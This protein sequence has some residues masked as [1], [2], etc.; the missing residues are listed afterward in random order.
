M[1]LLSF[2]TYMDAH[3]VLEEWDVSPFDGGFDG[4]RELQ[5][6]RFSGAVEAG[7]T[8]LFIRDGEPLAVLEDLQAESRPGDV[9]AFEDASG[10]TH[11]A[12]HPAAASLAAMLALGGEVRGQYFTDDT[13]LSKVHETLSEGGFTGYVELSENVLSGDYYVVYEGGDEDYL[14]V[15]GSSDRLVTSEEAKTKA[16]DEVGIYEVVAVHYPD[17]EIPDPA[18]EGEATPSQGATAGAAAGTESTADGDEAD[19]SDLTGE[20]ESTA[21]NERGEG[22]MVDP[23]SRP[24]ADPDPE[25]E[26]VP[27]PDPEP[28]SE[29]TDEPAPDP[30]PEP[31]SEPVPR[32]AAE[33]EADRREPRE[34]EPTADAAGT[35]RDEPSDDAVLDGVTARSVPSLDPERTG[36]ADSDRTS[37]VRNPNPGRGSDPEPGSEPEPEP[38]G[39]REAERRI[40]E[41][42]EDYERRIEELESEVEALRNERDRLRK[43]V[44]TL[45]SGDSTGETSDGPS[46]STSEALAGTSL[47]IREATRGEATMEDARAG[48]VGRESLAEN[49]RIEYHTQFEDQ[50]ATVDDLPFETWL[51][52]SARYEFV[53]WLILELLFEIQSTGAE[54]SMRHLYA[55]IPEIDRV[56]FDDAIAVGNGQE[57]REIT[58]DVVAR[59]RM[60]DPLVVAD[61]DESRDPT[62]AETLQPFL[63]NAEDVCVEHE[64][65]VGSF[66]VTSSYFEPDA[67]DTAREATSGS[68]LSREKYRSYVKIA[69]KKGFHLCLVESR[70]GSFHLAMPEL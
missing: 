35:D 52:S 51:R 38:V 22:L 36:R 24:G 45:E 32:E 59:N 11:E 21:A 43:R 14:A 67:L 26:R 42:R 47:F 15:I 25:P 65:L 62:R 4:L 1:P 10:R 49:L 33:P 7:A 70:K 54:S 23:R 41:L 12:P 2:P 28:E 6:R 63:G 58:F 30:E 56:G 57:G 5:S 9:D 64:T 69:R 20:P 40:E 27:E 66:A 29:P 31:E 8:W 44:S 46:L 55:A 61:I 13:P 16:E 17:L 18:T 3:T 68:L 53:E 19:E 37:Y 60:G 48:R 34:P 50:G 39:S